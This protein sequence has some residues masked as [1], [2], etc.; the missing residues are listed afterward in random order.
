MNRETPPA[1]PRC[2]KATILDGVI[3]VAATAAGLTLARTGIT[4][5]GWGASTDRID[6]L[7][8][9]TRLVSCLALGLSVGL[10][11]IRFRR[12][13]PSLREISQ[14]PGMIACS[15]VCLSVFIGAIVAIPTIVLA[16]SKPVSYTH[17][18]KNILVS[19]MS[20]A[21]IAHS[22]A[23][24]WMAQL[25]TATWRAEK[26]WIDQTGQTLGIFWILSMVFLSSLE[27]VPP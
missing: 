4:A 15:A 18:L 20:N 5:F 8:G 16:F 3:L 19:V 24:A 17:E 23:A 10:F 22:V 25:L 9:G 13:R 6:R 12:P 11:P 21:H 2:R 14:Q 1:S 7:A 27:M 26:G